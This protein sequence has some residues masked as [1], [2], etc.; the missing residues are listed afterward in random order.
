M[1]RLFI[2]LALSICLVGCSTDDKTES[3]GENNTPSEQENEKVNQTPRF[4]L[5]ET[6]T[7]T[8]E[9]DEQY[10]VTFTGIE[11]TDRR[12]EFAEETPQRV[13]I[14]SYKYKNISC[15]D[16]LFI[17][18]MDFNAYDS[19]GMALSTYPDISVEYPDSVSTGRSTKGS[20][21]YGLDSDVNHIELEYYTNIFNS[22]PDCIV[23]IDW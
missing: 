19:D 10:E 9:S 6:I 8:L 3:I 20:V 7:V 13:V 17:S 23:D 4:A 16:D 5:G 12:N 11:E 15:E 22:K 14:I 2:L 21:A 18:D 1:K